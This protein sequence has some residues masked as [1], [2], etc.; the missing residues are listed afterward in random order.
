MT[1]RIHIGVHKTATTELQQ[2]LKA[3]EWRLARG[4]MCYLRPDGL[5]GRMVQLEKVLGDP[6]TQATQLAQ[7][8]LAQATDGLGHLLLSEE[9]I[10]G[11]TRRA[12]VLGQ[13]G[14]V[15]PAAQDRLACLLALLNRAE[16]EIFMAV[17]DPASFLTSTFGQQLR[18]PMP[19]HEDVYLRDFRLQAFSWA[20]LARR[21]LAV[22]GVRRLTVWRYEDYAALRP[23]I[24]QAMIGRRA[25]QRVA[26]A[27]MV[28]PGI[29]QAAYDAFVAA[30]LEDSDT[31]TRTLLAAACRRFP[32]AEG[33]A[34]MRILAPELHA[35]SQHRYASDMDDLAGLDRVRLLRPDGQGD[36]PS[37]LA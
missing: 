8:R 28:N 21:L 20:D 25:A 37:A 31:P 3:V 13:G 10:L 15:Y 34:P 36:D 33:V 27:Q 23:Q 22:P 30:A 19:V 26:P 9:N 6:G 29:S 14:A 16:A 2:A 18:Q 11:T 7:A 24:L 35:E 32:K 1:T 12:S 5:R 17:R 4:G